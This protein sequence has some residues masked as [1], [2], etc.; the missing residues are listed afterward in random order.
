M[1]VAVGAIGFV[2][3]WRLTRSTA[4]FETLLILPLFL[5]LA[6]QENWTFVNKMNVGLLFF[7]SLVCW[8]L[9]GLSAVVGRPWV[10]GGWVVGVT[11][12]L[13]LLI[14]EAAHIDAPADAR[15]I[16]LVETEIPGA[17][18]HEPSGYLL[19][20][21]RRAL[22][23]ALWPDFTRLGDFSEFSLRGSLRR[24]FEK[25]GRAGSRGRHTPY[26]WYVHEIADASRSVTVALDLSAP[27]WG[28]TDLLSLT[29]QDAD[30]NLER[31]RG[32]PCILEVHVDWSPRTLY[33]MAQSGRDF[34]G[35]QGLLLFFGPKGPHAGEGHGRGVVEIPFLEE[36]YDD[37]V[38]AMGC[39]PC[40]SRVDMSRFF[41]GGVDTGGGT[42][43][44][45]GS[46]PRL[47]LHTGAVSLMVC[48]N[49]E[50]DRYRL[51]KASATSTGVDVRRPVDV[52]H[53]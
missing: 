37:F 21:R 46:M 30:L 20:S 13:F 52:Y 11:L 4:L 35:V 22:D 28:R 1:L 7:P 40:R 51:W 15:Y 31:C 23:V 3:R 8:V 10:H 41:K 39:K 25:R 2:H 33:L 17:S 34:R 16:E 44:V 42:V 24:V 26:G 38:S 36:L 29:D 18:I 27:P 48:L 50:G 43:R 45:I 14:P 5:S 12:L 47:R 19:E 49:P 32:R 6:V 53:N 9:A